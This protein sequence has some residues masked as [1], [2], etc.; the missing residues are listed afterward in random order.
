MRPYSPRARRR[1]PRLPVPVVRRAAPAGVVLVLLLA[2][3]LLHAAAPA[4]TAPRPPVRR[5]DVSDGLAH[6][7]VRALLVDS[8]GYLWVGTEEG[9]SRFDGYQFR[10]YGRGLP[11][12]FVTDLIEGPGGTIWIATN[13]G[14]AR[15]EEPSLAPREGRTPR[16]V[17]V[18]VGSTGV[19]NQINALAVDTSGR[20]WCAT[21]DG[22]FRSRTRAGPDPSFD[23][24]ALPLGDGDR[25][26][27]RKVVARPTGGVVVAVR[28]SERNGIWTLLAL[29]DGP[30]A[31]GAVTIARSLHGDITAVAVQDGRVLLILDG[32]L[33]RFEPGPTGWVET[34]PAAAPPAGGVFAALHV[35]AGGM[36][37]MGT[38]H[39][40]YQQHPDGSWA[41]VSLGAAPAVSVRALAQQADGTMWVGSV[42]QGIFR[43]LPLAIESWT[44]AAGLNDPDVR[45]VIQGPDGRIYAVTPTQVV[46][47]RDGHLVPVVT[48]SA[49]LNDPGP[50]LSLASD[51]TWW[52]M[53]NNRIVQIPGGAPRLDRPS[54]VYRPDDGRMQWSHTAT[55]A[56][57]PFID[58]SGR[59]WSAQVGAL[60]RLDPAVPAATRFARV[61]VDVGRSRRIKVIYQDERGRLWLGGN[62]ALGILEGDRVR[63]FQ[64]SAGLPETQPRSILQDSRGWVWVGL[65]YSG[66]SV[67]RHPQADIPEFDNYDQSDGL[68]SDTVW[69]L[70]EDARGRVYMGT[71]RGLD[72][73]DPTTGRIRRF[74]TADG[75]AGDLVRTCYRDRSGVIWVGTSEGL[76]RLDPRTETDA[77]GSPPV[78]LSRVQVAGENLPVSERG[79]A[80]VGPLSL[81]AAHDN[82][83]IEFVAPNLQNGPVTYEYRLQG[84]DTDWSPPTEVRNVNYAHL[85][86]GR[87]RFEVRAVTWDG[88]VSTQPASLTFRIRPP[89]WRE[90][91][92][93][94]LGAAVV[95]AGGVLLHRIRVHQA[96][97][98]ERVRRRIA[99]DLHDDLGAALSQVAVLSEVARRA[100]PSDNQGRTLQTIGD[101]AR[102]MRASMGD[103]VWAIDPRKDHLSDLIVRVREIATNVLEARGVQV[104]FTAIAP[105]E[106]ERIG[107][108]PDQR[109]QVLLFCKEAI[110]NAGRHAQASSVTIGFE[111]ANRSLTVR[112]ADDG[113]GFDPD[114]APAG[115]GLANLHE[116]VAA[117]GGRLV[118]ET[119]PGQG[120]RLAATIP[121]GGYRS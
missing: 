105:H 111:L 86:P 74:G 61:P 33:T 38:N 83:L 32:R 58:R 37:W 35:G 66:V 17:T 79:A 36:L 7:S 49:A 3:R 34:H 20:F 18:A 71:G 25:E 11:L 4:A 121:I 110:S 107:L 64:T 48:V 100:G 50:S 85:A 5:F 55:R 30:G 77:S 82:L 59:V 14:L 27:V 69:S 23:R 60:Y 43:L 67:T 98:L 51:G 104:Y 94:L 22:L 115:R 31:P 90:P 6:S 56:P 8:R 116:R 118:V 113:V 10:N 70:C 92:F 84:A 75:L 16:F 41:A 103:I 42:R 72:R 63:Y 97:A 80:T 93:L 2:G 120:T 81:D 119:G 47:V 102:S 91:W 53:G 112:V 109:R 99:I 57:T 68:S 40:L 88:R 65:R 73:L 21:D 78:Y 24:V 101:L 28:T 106:M 96:V 95:A 9:V 62:T 15:F 46:E 117:L 45:Q 1:N 13:G 12:P 89:V 44:V 19:S 39:G 108:G 26:E 29:D 54:R 52:A 114:A 87:Y 76:S